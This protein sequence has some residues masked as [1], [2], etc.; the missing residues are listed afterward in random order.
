MKKSFSP[1]DLDLS[2]AIPA[3]R[4]TLH[5]AYDVPAL[6]AVADLVHVMTYDYASY[7]NGLIGTNAPLWAT[8]EEDASKPWAQTVNRSLT[9]L[10][11]LGAD[12]K[13]T[14]LGVPFYGRTF[15]ADSADRAELGGSCSKDLALAGPITNEQG[16][17][18]FMEICN[19]TLNYARWE[20]AWDAE[21]QTPSM[22]SGKKYVSY[23]DLKSVRAKAEYASKTGLAGVMVWSIDTDD[24]RG[25]CGLLGGGYDTFP[26]LR[27]INRVLEENSGGAKV[28]CGVQRLVGSVLVAFLAA[29]LLA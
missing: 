6:Y 22:K 28:E 20:H 12:P 7:H 11:K 5:S 26:L 27:T 4:W 17:L 19:I 3:D 9:A 24:F 25:A 13:K 2:V 10:L 21:R 29:K 14:V 8:R 23:D 15:L 16:Y 1:H 18:G